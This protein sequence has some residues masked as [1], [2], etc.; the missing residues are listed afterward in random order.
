MRRRP[1]LINSAR[2]FPIDTKFWCYGG[3]IERVKDEKREGKRKEKRKKK[4]T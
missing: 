2:G 4:F 3:E 1:A